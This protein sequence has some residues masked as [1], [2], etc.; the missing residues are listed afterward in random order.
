MSNATNPTAVVAP[1]AALSVGAV[2][3]IKA[4]NRGSLRT[5]L[6]EPA[7]LCEP[8]S[9]YVYSPGVVA[10]GIIPVADMPT[11]AAA[12]ALWNGESAGGKSY[13]IEV[14]SAHSASGTMGIGASLIVGVTPVAQ[15]AAVANGTGVVLGSCTGDPSSGTRAK[16][17]TGITLT[18]APAWVPVAT[19][20]GIS[21]VNVG[22]AMIAYLDG[23]YIVP[24][25]FCFAMNVLAPVG[26]TAKYSFSVTW[27]ELILNA[28]A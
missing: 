12:M 27:R 7:R 26:T 22:N 4:T 10:N 14:A 28:Y 25:G 17:G 8:A 11:T 5:A 13:A 24:P 18:G 3:P 6:A 2:F 1:S 16:F 21:E 23:L 9:R 20:K 19:T 15:A